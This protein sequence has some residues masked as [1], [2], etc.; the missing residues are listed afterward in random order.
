MTGKFKRFGPR[1][2]ISI[3]PEDHDAL[4][5]LAGADDVSV[6]WV[7]RKAIKSYLIENRSRVANAAND[8]S[9]DNANG[10]GPVGLKR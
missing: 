5:K 4:Y 8:R 10:A 9:N 7:I 2:T 1:V 6:S 3:R